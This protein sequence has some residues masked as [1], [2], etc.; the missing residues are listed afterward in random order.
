MS[1][2]ATKWLLLE[3]ILPLLG[4]G[5]LYVI[6]GGCRYVVS[7]D[8]TKFAFE[9]APALDPLGWLYG[10][11]IISC[12]SG[13]RA[14]PVSNAGVLPYVCFAAAAI[15]FLLLVSAMT[16]RGASAAW[17]PPPL[18]KIF[19]GGLVVAILFAGFRVQSLVTA[20]AQS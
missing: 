18:L 17:Q 1:Y 10:A 4:A 11:V 9:W 16:E 3:G 8:P 20:G 13:L 5:I 12:Q 19:S 15:C 14:L 6:W 7:S 2:L